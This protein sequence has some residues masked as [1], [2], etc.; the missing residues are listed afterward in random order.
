MSCP[1]LTESGNAFLL[2]DVGEIEM[3]ACGDPPAPPADSIGEWVF[4]VHVSAPFVRSVSVTPVRV[5]P[6]RLSEDL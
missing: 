1:I 5:L 3:E 4:E 2:E 6:G